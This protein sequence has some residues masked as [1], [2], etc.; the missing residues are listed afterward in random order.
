MALCVD[1]AVKVRP[2]PFIG[3]RSTAPVPIRGN[4]G[5]YEVDAVYDE[6][7]TQD[8]VFVGSVLPAVDKFLQVSS[9][10]H[11]RTGAWCPPLGKP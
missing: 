5:Q 11:A 9:W 3:Y 4:T 1:V 10:A 2:L 6:G 7:S 8:S